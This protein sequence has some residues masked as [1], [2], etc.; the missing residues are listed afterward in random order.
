[1]PMEPVEPANATRVAVMAPK[2][3]EETVRRSYTPGTR[4]NTRTK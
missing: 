3:T 2:G 1:V 4:S